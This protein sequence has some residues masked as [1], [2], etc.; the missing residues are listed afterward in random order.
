MKQ[1]NL[2]NIEQSVLQVVHD[3][4]TYVSQVYVDALKTSDSWDSAA[5]ESAREK[6]MEYI[7][8]HLNADMLKFLTEQATVTV[9]Q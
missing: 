1:D 7:E 3:A 9:E 8:D 2:N 5:M 4:V 6:A